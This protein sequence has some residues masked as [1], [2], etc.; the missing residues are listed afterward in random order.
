MGRGDWR[1]SDEGRVAAAEQMR[2]RWADPQYRLDM[3]E[4]Q[5]RRWTDPVYREHTSA[6]VSAAKQGHEVTVETRARI[7][8][9][10]LRIGKRPPSTR[11]RVRPRDEVER[12][13]DAIRGYRWTPEAKARLSALRKEQWR[14]P[15]FRE[16]L[17]VPLREAA[18]RPEERERRRQAALRRN[19]TEDGQPRRRSVIPPLV[20]EHVLARDGLVCGLCG[21]RINPE[22][23][24]PNPQSLSLDH[25]VPVVRGGSHDPSNLRPAHR[26][27]NSAKGARIGR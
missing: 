10:H 5:R 23:K 19:G 16:R 4:R 12:R 21:D 26:G 17:V 15:G 8:A 11:G 1:K 6:L 9:T 25:I 27:C 13:A 24:S 18:R 2:Q 14:D 22:V 20:R 7:R 3:A